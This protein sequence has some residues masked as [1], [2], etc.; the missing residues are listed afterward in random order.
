M[1]DLI[2]NRRLSSR[3]VDGRI[4]VSPRALAAPQPSEDAA[5]SDE[6]VDP[7]LELLRSPG[8][9]AQEQFLEQLLRQ[10]SSEVATV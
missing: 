6:R 5:A 2:F 3:P 10:R 1:Y 8:E 4:C 7:L 9:L